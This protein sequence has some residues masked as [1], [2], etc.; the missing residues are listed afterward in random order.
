MQWWWDEL[1]YAPGAW[2]DIGD[3]V[4]QP[5]PL[6]FAV[7]GDEETIEEAVEEAIP[8]AEKIAT[9]FVLR[10]SPAPPPK[11]VFPG[12]WVGWSPPPHPVD[13]I[14]SFDPKASKK[15]KAAAVLLDYYHDNAL[16][17]WADDGN[18]KKCFIG[19][20]DP[21]KEDHDPL[22][23]VAAYLDPN[24]K[25]WKCP[26][27]S[28]KQLDDA[29]QSAIGRRMKLG[30][31]PKASYDLGP[32]NT[33]PIVIYYYDHD[34]MKRISYPPMSI[35]EAL[36]VSLTSPT[37]HYWAVYSGP[38]DTASAEAGLDK[39]HT[40]QTADPK[41]IQIERENPGWKNRAEL[42]KILAKYPK[43][44]A[45]SGECPSCKGSLG[46]SSMQA[47]SAGQWGDEGFDW[48][49]DVA[50][51]GII[52]SITGAILALVSAVLTATGV[53]AIVGVP[54]AIAT[55]LIVAA[56]ND[57]DVGLHTGDFGA[58]LAGIA[59]ALI[60]AA[61]SA[62]GQAGMSIPPEAMK[63]LGGTVTAIA[64]AVRAGQEK[65]LDFAQIWDE[66][67]K[68]VQG[69]GKIGDNEAIAI[70]QMLTGQGPAAGHVFTQGYL[71]GKFLD[72]PAI[73]SIAKLLQA[74][75]AFADPRIINLGLLGMGIGYISKTQ[76]GST[77]RGASSGVTLP[78]GAPRAAAAPKSG[79]RRPQRRGAQH[80]SRGDFA[81]QIFIE[82]KQAAL[83]DLDA[84]VVAV[85]GPRYNLG[86]SPVVGFECPPGF[87]LVATESGQI[88]CAFHGKSSCLA[89]GL[90]E[91][92]NFVCTVR[93]FDC[94]PG[95]M[96]R[97]GSPPNW[98]FPM[99]GHMTGQQP[100]PPP[101]PPQGPPDWSF[102]ALG[103]PHGYWRDD[104]SGKCRPI[105][106]PQ[107]LPSPRTSYY[108]D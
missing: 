99:G 23:L 60:Q 74:Y 83:D 107:P 51:T 96:V 25:V 92:G 10:H 27:V 17:S 104:L 39:I 15:E 3:V 73:A 22:L 43:D 85:L 66:A 20:K 32:S 14:V 52:G 80:A 75:A 67:A 7:L 5:L 35:P 82:G 108:D 48:D 6:E 70:A 59:T 105:E 47:G 40:L 53:G 44:F 89:G 33:N 31:L 38:G 68:K 18:V 50:G 19:T 26:G 61:G 16:R 91:R 13:V 71:A 29:V 100:L 90:D 87:D 46:L 93:D 8:D 2:Q 36:R 58:G 81:G 28:W 86:R 88:A 72:M 97:K 12:T 94:P 24:H 77:F 56:I 106:P 84:F 103:C 102:P 21:K 1:Y 65:K 45:Q 95:M 63:A 79:S 54:L 98:C 76:G 37:A 4:Y 64:A 49:R 42:K 78:A 41:R 30:P 101:P 11:P 62:A 34:L 9:D 57:L 55:P 69:S